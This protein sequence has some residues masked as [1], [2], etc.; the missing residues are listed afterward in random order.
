[1]KVALLKT[2]EFL[3]SCIKYIGYAGWT[4]AAALAGYQSTLPNK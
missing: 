1:M 2:T 3:E 4:A